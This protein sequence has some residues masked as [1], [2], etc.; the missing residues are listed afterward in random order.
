MLYASSENIGQSA[1][2]VRAFWDRWGINEQ[3]K[4]L[5]YWDKN[6]P[7][8]TNAADVFASVYTNEGKVADLRGELGQ[9]VE[10]GHLDDRLEG[11]GHRSGAARRSPCRTSGASRSRRSRSTSPSRSPSSPARASSSAW[12]AWLHSRPSP[13]NC[14]RGGRAHQACP[15]TPAGPGRAGD[16]TDSALAHRRIAGRRN[17][18]CCSEQETGWHT[19]V[20]REP[21]S[22][23]SRIALEE[24]PSWMR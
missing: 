11:V 15:V 4:T 7:V 24:G 20:G 21:C 9:G 17:Q 5:G 19:T 6:C 2:D 23:G 12:K 16:A 10:V 8:K 3:T 14:T 13:G 18:S 1:A 22:P